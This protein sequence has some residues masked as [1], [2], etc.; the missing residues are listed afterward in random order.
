[1]RASDTLYYFQS[2]DGI[3]QS[4]SRNKLGNLLGLDLDLFP[5]LGIS[6]LPVLKM[7]SGLIR[8]VNSISIKY[9]GF[10]LQTA[11]AG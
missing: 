9:R 3:L 8:F 10:Q 7:I 11:L 5:G 1:M 2:S 6:F 4:L